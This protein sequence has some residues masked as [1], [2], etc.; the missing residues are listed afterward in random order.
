VYA[1]VKLHILG[2]EQI[3]LFQAGE[4]RCKHA[5]GLCELFYTNISREP[6]QSTFDQ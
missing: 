6:I 5:N 4:L 2:A 1:C 3:A